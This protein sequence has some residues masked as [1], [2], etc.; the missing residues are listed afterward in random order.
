MAWSTQNVGVV[1]ALLISIYFYT[2]LNPEDG[3]GKVEIPLIIENFSI[4][5]HSPQ[6]KELIMDPDT[7]R[8]EVLARGFIWSEGPLWLPKGKGPQNAKGKLLFVDTQKNTIYSW[9]EDEGLQVF[10]KD[11]FQGD[12]KRWTEPGANGLALYGDYLVF[13][14]HGNRQ[15]S[16]IRL[17][18]I[19]IG[20]ALPVSKKKNLATHFNGKHLSSPNDVVILD[21]PSDAKD[22]SEPLLFFTD[23]PY[24]LQDH[25]CNEDKGNLNSHPSKEL[26][27]SGIYLLRDPNLK[28]GSAAAES[29]VIL[30]NKE[31]NRPNG[32]DIFP[33]GKR[34]LVAN[35]DPKQPL[36]KVFDLEG[37]FNQMASSSSS[38]FPE[39]SF[40]LEGKTFYDGNQLL[41]N[42][43]GLPDG[44]AFDSRG[45]VY[46]SGPGG[47]YIFDEDGELLGMIN[48]GKRVSNCC[49]SDDGYDLYVTSH[50]TLVRVRLAKK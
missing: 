38:S 23:P 8:I 4:I 11:I 34:L 35:S 24:G 19:E 40:L 49:F 25:E 47:V 2:T 46:S 16:A 14:E 1:L 28:G 5:A 31:L 7:S 18:D 10:V 22:H 48:L 15:V 29:Q 37:L 27:F 42:G 39:N 26:P 32:I 6:F 3:S 41:K 33:G 50:D 20:K 9:S 44:F 43:P 30:L 17:D 13:C 45:N 36:W 21:H 12:L